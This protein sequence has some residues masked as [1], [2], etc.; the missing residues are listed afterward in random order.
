ML[1]FRA[2]YFFTVLVVVLF[3]GFINKVN[4]QENDDEADEKVAVEIAKVKKRYEKEIDDLKVFYWRYLRERLDQ[5]KS[6]TLKEKNEAIFVK[7][8]ELLEKIE[9][10]ESQKEYSKILSEL[11]I[12]DEHKIKAIADDKARLKVYFAKLEAIDQEHFEKVRKKE[13]E[14]LF[15]EFLNQA[16]T[17]AAASKYE[18]MR[19]AFLQLITEN[20]A[21]RKNAQLIEISKVLNVLLA[22]RNQAFLILKLSIGLKLRVRGIEVTIDSFDGETL[23]V[24]DYQKN[25]KS[26]LFNEFSLNDW[27][28]LMGL[29]FYDG[30]FIYQNGL[31]YYLEGQ[32]KKAQESLL[33]ASKK[34]I[35]CRTYLFATEAKLGDIHRSTLL[36][37]SRLIDQ[38]KYREAESILARIIKENPNELEALF[39]QGEIRV[40][41]DRIAE[42]Y[43]YYENLHKKYPDHEETLRAL[44]DLGHKLK[45]SDSYLWSVKLLEKNP[46]DKE[47]LT[48][49]C[50]EMKKL[51]KYDKYLEY[52]LRIQKTNPALIE[53]NLFLADAYLM[54]KKYPE[55]QAQYEKMLKDKPTQWDAQQGYGESLNQQKKYKEALEYYEKLVPTLKSE[56][57]KA[58]IRKRIKEL[59]ER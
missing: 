12:F 2:H 50:R 49:A 28:T 40:K 27:L 15:E 36:E 34:G 18:E 54:N 51:E 13:N 45:L 25:K 43:G 58:T 23:L 29:R 32:Y 56:T 19:E 20:P 16:S 39:M 26:Y 38:K 59:L 7:W 22:S 55:A 48:I 44:A 53:P 30:Q 17:L 4:G 1:C 6:E 3:F 31:K 35:D 9:E 57:K 21:Y 11:A 52:A 5:V 47:Q 41:Q 10:L 14:I 46:E 37:A 24:T 42:A 33:M 8:R